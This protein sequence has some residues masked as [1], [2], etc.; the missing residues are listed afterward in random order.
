MIET[1]EMDERGIF[2]QILITLFFSF[3]FLLGTIGNLWVFFAV[4]YH[5]AIQLD[6]ISVNRFVFSQKMK[7]SR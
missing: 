1:I 7:Y 2:V 3:A 6:I 4:K 5:R